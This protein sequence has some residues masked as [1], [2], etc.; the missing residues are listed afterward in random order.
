MRAS[1]TQT[2]KP[3]GLLATLMF[4]LAVVLAVTMIAMTVG[5]SRANAATW[6]SSCPGFSSLW[7]ILPAYRVLM[8]WVYDRA[9]E[10]LLVVMLMH[11]S[12]TAS[13][14]ILGPLATGSALAT[15]TLVFAAALWVIVAVV[16]VANYGHLTRQP[17]L[18]GRVA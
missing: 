11:A 12:L 10:S 6:P 5:A 9:G 18:R 4:L 2:L 8:V 3:R 15:Y 1:T 13:M 17:P 7:G 16:A 14:L